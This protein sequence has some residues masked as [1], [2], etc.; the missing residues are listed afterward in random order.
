MVICRLLTTQ[1]VQDQKARKAVR[2]LHSPMGADI[3]ELLWQI[4]ADLPLWQK[5]AFAV[6]AGLAVG[7][8]VVLLDLRQPRS[9]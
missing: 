9:A 2:D 7:G 6:A 8:L 4:F 5:A 3:F 1:I